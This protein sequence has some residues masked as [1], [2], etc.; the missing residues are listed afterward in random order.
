VDIP[1]FPITGP[2]NLLQRINE[3][4]RNLPGVCELY[5]FGSL[6]NGTSDAYSDI[7]LE[8]ATQDIATSPAALDYVLTSVAPIEA[9]WQMQTPCDAIAKTILFR[10]EAYYHKLD[11]GL[12]ALGQIPD[13][14]QSPELPCCVVAHRTARLLQPGCVG[15]CVHAKARYAGAL[16]CRQATRRHSVRESE[17]TRSALDLLVVRFGPG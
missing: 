10:G 17:Q 3:A 9:V 11:I 6:A 14:A 15:Y 8:V 12:H 2:H 13:G 4:L 7:D 16:C 5:V 1:E